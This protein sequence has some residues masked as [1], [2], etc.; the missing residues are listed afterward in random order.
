M[1]KRLVGD[2]LNVNFV[3]KKYRYG[4]PTKTI[5]RNLC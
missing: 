4:R 5:L 2:K 1:E 3:N